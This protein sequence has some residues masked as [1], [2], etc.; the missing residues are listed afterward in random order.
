LE[1]VNGFS[2]ANFERLSNQLKPEYFNF[3]K[4]LSRVNDGAQTIVKM[5]EDLLGIIADSKL[6]YCL[7]PL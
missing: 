1:F 4:S 7:C 5:R 2:S 3:F 6:H